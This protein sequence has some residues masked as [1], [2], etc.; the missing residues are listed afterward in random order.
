V[1]EEIKTAYE[2]MRLKKGEV[3]LVLYTSGKLLLQGKPEA[4][5]NVAK[6]IEKLGMGEKEKT[7]KF[8]QE[9][10]WIIGSDEALKGDTFGGI[11]VAAV[12][13]NDEVRLRLI[14][15]GVQDSKNL[16]DKEV[17]LMAEK[18]KKI[19]ACKIESLLPEEYNH[20]HHS[21]NIT[22]LLDKLHQEAAQYL[23]PGKHIVDKY[24]GCSVGDVREEKAESKY[25]E[26]AAASVLARAAGLQQLD[27]L[28]GLAGFPLPKGSSHVKLALQELKE[29]KLDFRKFVK[30]DFQNV[31]E[32]LK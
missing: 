9:T 6:E 20:H 32:F 22:V 21:Q 23:L 8:R 18:I 5:E 12:K 3:T 13:A 28:S 31:H 25:V 1:K 10:G 26:V 30:M 27:Y 17:L 14:E 4:V 24:P 2:E 15:L 19:V 7:E 29:R 11:V 16:S